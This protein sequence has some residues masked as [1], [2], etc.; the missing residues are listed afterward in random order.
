MAAYFSIILV[1]ATL[2]TGL[3]WLYDLVFL[4]PKRKA[5][6]ALAQEARPDLDQATKDGI[7]RESAIVETAH[8]VF[9]V[10]AFVM[11]LR[12]FIYEPFQIPSGSM[13]PT[14]LVGDFILVE[15]FSY[16]LRDP[17]WRTKLVETGEAERGDVAVFKYPE[18]T[19]IDYI[20]RVVGLPGDTVIY[21]NKQL[22]LKPACDGSNQAECAAPYLVHRSELN[23]GDFV[24]DGVPLIEYQE[25]LGKVEHHILINP[26]RPDA[27]AYYYDQAGLPV[28]EWIV[29]EGQYFVMGDNRDNSKDS[30]FWGFVPEANLVGKAVAIWISF[31]FDRQPSDWLPTWLPSGVRFNRIGGIV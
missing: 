15:K 10:I 1:L 11:V 2:I 30:R 16:G 6:L 24:Q 27:T 4:A 13:M 29:P 22:W 12:S 23:R 5:Q 3:I 26:M 21:K 28:G 20:K 7:L 19:R 31:E 17:V 8:S 9:P 18:D 14:L 25:Q